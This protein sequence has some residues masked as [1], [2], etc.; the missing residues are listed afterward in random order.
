MYH[1]FLIVKPPTFSYAIGAQCL[2]DLCCQQLRDPDCGPMLR[3]LERGDLPR[4]DKKLILDS[5]VYELE[6]GVLFRVLPD[7]TLRTIVPQEARRKLFDE[8]HAGT[9]GA[10]QRMEKIH[11]ILSKHY[12]WPAM[13]KDIKAWCQAC[14]ACFT[15]AAGPPPHIPLTPIPMAGLWDRVGVDVL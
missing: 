1:V 14:E 13:R 8:T 2:R 3:Y 11:A 9:F 12:W 5:V 15:R 6:S 4:E 10:H 7:K